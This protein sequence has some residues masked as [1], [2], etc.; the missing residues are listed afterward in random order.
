MN[1]GFD[2]KADLNKLEFIYGADVYGPITEKENL[3]ILEKV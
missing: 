2:I 1:T 3:M